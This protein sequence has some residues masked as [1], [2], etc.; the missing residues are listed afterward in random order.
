[1]SAI[2]QSII[3]S[4]RPTCLDTLIT[5]G[6]PY[7]VLLVVVLGL[8]ALEGALIQTLVMS[9]DLFRFLV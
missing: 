3:A 2:N 9:S 7:D 5:L 6:W 1:M 8:I 4:P